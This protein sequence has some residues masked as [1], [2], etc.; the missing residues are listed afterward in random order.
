[1]KPYA[2][3]V[4]SILVLS[5]LAGCSGSDGE[6]LAQYNDECASFGYRMG[7]PE[8]DNCRLQQ[9]WPAWSYRP[10]QYGFLAHGGDAMAPNYRNRMR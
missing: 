3:A 10:R 1:M 4:L 6:K 5:G 8:F 2:Y 9:E 7:T